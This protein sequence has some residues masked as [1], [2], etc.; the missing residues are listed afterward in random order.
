MGEE[1]RLSGELKNHPF[2]ALFQV[3]VL[4]TLLLGTSGCLLLLGAGAGVGGTA[5]YMGKL[6]D[7][8]NG[9]V[10]KVRH[11]T[12][13]GLKKLE[14]PIIKDQGDKLSGKVES[15]TADDQKVWISIDSLAPSRS[16]VSIRVGYLG[17]EAR[18][19]RILQAIRGR[20]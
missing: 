10:P 15:V 16:K 5:F 14:M 17:N 3:L 12:V 13:A 18:S 6:E 20:V 9:S 2:F 4:A 1:M 7:E 19:R 8:V 11:A